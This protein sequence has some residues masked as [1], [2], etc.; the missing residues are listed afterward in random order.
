MAYSHMTPTENCPLTVV[1]PQL[2][3]FIHIKYTVFQTLK[4][5]S[6]DEE[7]EGLALTVQRHLE[8]E[9]SNV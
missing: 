1:Y 4:L 3:S 7:W 5:L 9:M 8:P 6:H 2:P